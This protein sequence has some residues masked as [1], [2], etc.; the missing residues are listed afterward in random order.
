MHGILRWLP[1]NSSATLR[2]GDS[3][4]NTLQGA[5]GHDVLLGHGHPDLLIGDLDDAPVLARDILVGGGGADSFYFQSL[6]NRGRDADVIIDFKPGTDAIILDFGFLPGEKD[7]GY[8]Y[9]PAHVDKD[10]FTYGREAKDADDF[11]IYRKKTGA[12]FIDTDGTGPEASHKVAILA[13]H[14]K[15]HASDLHV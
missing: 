5:D 10:N 3:T 4:T 1:K 12:L 7:K 8:G 14:A 13:N 11:V 9:R 2:I 15:I 6:P